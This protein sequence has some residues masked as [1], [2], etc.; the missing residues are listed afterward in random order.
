MRKNWKQLGAYVSMLNDVLQTARKMGNQTLVDVCTTERKTI[1]KDIGN[2][3]NN[4][5]FFDEWVDWGCPSVDDETFH[6]FRLVLEGFSKE[7]AFQEYQ[8]LSI[9]LHRERIKDE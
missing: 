6:F 4:G 2:E 1:L 3:N 9:D 8:D 5:V 7:I